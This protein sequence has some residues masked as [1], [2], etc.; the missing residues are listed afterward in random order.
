MK[1]SLNYNNVL[2]R[3]IPDENA[4]NGGLYSLRSLMYCTVAGVLY[5]VNQN[6][7]DS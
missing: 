1:I 4:S 7:F 6:I 5:F 2:Y 3:P